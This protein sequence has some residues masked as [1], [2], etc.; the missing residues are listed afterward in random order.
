[1]PARKRR[2][3][4]VGVVAALHREL[5]ALAEPAPDRRA[6]LRLALARDVE[7]AGR[8]RPGVEVLV[9]AA[10]GEL[11]AG[12][13]QADRDRAGRV[14]EVPDQR[15]AAPRRRGLERRQVGERAA[16]VVDVRE[17][18]DVARPA[19]ERGRVG[20]AVELA[21]R[22]PALG[23]DPL[24]HVAVGREVAAVG[25]ERAGRRASIAAPTS[26]NRLTVVES[27]T[28]TSPGPG[29]DQRRERV[30]GALGRVDPVRPAA[31]E[32][33]APL[34]RSPPRAARASRRGSRPSELPSR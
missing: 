6:Q 28:S 2:I 23:R 11:R 10:D 13:A 25:D 4:G 12:G 5:V 21:Q 26:L 29:A 15:R 20:L 16:A 32:P 1:M 14:A 22:E 33:L 8:A 19:R 7:V 27:Q 34:R 18:D 17:D 31:D 30:A 9:R 3:D 24:E